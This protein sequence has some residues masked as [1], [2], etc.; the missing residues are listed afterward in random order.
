[1]PTTRSEHGKDLAIVGP[2]MIG[3]PFGIGVGAAFRQEDQDLHNRFNDAIRAA[4]ADGTIKRLGL[5][6]FG[7]DVSVK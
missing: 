1:V 6:W 5:Q 3:G 4:K 7:Y 2:T